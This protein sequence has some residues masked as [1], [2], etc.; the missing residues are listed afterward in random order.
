MGKI[1]VFLFWH[2]RNLAFSFWIRKNVSFIHP[3]KLRHQTKSPREHLQNDFFIFSLAP[4][5]YHML[6]IPVLISV[7][8]PRAEE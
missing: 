8:Y 2:G 3:V 1:D 7:G 4:P 5:S 6:L